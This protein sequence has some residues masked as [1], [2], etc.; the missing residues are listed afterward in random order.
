MATGYFYFRPPHNRPCRQPGS[1]RRGSV[2]HV[3]SLADI[4]GVEAVENYLRHL[5]E[6][7]GGTWLPHAGTCITTLLVLARD[8]VKVDQPTLARLQELRT[9]IYQ[10]LT[11]KRKP[12]LSERVSL[13]LMPFDDEKLLRRFFQL[14]T[15]LYKE[16]HD[17]LKKASRGATGVAA[18]HRYEEG[19]MLD[20]QQSDPMRRFNLASITSKQTSCVASGTASSASSSGPTVSRSASRSTRPSTRILPGALRST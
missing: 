3:H 15:D 13:K 12:D 16:A 7:S 10:R 17:R 6:R 18:A 8:F 1:R 20:F 5:H 2:E 9:I 11:A 19:L 4:A 14:P